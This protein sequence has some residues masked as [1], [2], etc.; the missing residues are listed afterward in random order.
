[1]RGLILTHGDSDHLGFAERLRQT[2]VP[3]FV[4][5]ADAA[6][7]TGETKKRN[8]SWAGWS[9]PLLDSSGTQRDMAGC[10]SPRS[11]RSTTRRM[12][13]P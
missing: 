11:Q 3:V 7:A 9:V 13:R 12:E 8:P 2:G 4:H 1:V 6:L 5:Q 10:V